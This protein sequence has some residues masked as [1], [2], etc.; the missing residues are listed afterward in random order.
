MDMLTK[1]VRSTLFTFFVDLKYMFT[2][3]MTHNF[4]LK[5][6]MSVCIVTNATAFLIRLAVST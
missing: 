3:K 1:G 2:E 5:G 6:S 4:R